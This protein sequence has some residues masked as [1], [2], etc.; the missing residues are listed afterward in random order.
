MEDP[1]QRELNAN[2]SR[3]GSG[4]D[5]D[6]WP[7]SARHCGLFLPGHMVHFIQARHGWEDRDGHEHG[8]LRAVDGTLLTVAF[9]DREQR[10]RN[11]ETARMEAIAERLGP[12]VVYQRRLGLLSFPRPSGSLLFCV[13]DA[14]AEWRPCGG[15]SGAGPA[16]AAEA[17]DALLN[18]GGFMARLRPERPTPG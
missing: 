7:P 10:L 1:S 12:R 16:D 17:L 11:H 14:D 5:P 18:R 9:G 8:V 3:A 2:V 13:A 15:G 6:E 4:G